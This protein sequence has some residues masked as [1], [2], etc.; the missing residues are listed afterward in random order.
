MVKKG[1]K[2]RSAWSVIGIILLFLVGAWFLA[3]LIPALIGST[4]VGTGNVARIPI[5]G[6]ILTE[7]PDSF[8][9][10]DM[11]SSTDIARFIRKADKHPTVKVIL[12]E[13]NSPGG[14]AV[15]AEEIAEAVR[16]AEKPTIA[17]IRDI[18]LSAGYWIAS[19]ADEVYASRLSLV[20]SIGVIGSYLEFSGLFDKY[21]I[22]YQRMVAGEY[23]DIG[24]P[25]KPITEREE[26]LFQTQ[27][28][29]LH[30]IFIET[31]AEQRGMAFED[32]ELLA[33]GEFFIGDIAWEHGLI[34]GTMSPARLKDHLE[35]KVGSRPSYV[36]YE[37]SKGLLGLFSNQAGNMAY[38]A[39]RGIGSSLF[40]A[41]LASSAKILI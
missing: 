17:Y 36:E 35:D 16:E 24:S 6:V 40:D 30:V 18:G 38:W 10:A 39:G 8:F 2:R 5:T 41:S 27:L 15:A 22:T 37:K 28:D 29:A 31:V 33:T 25:F 1:G 23:K 21:G 32:V 4:D 14:S 3:I 19:S 7:S 34:D 11:T 13:I 20:G 26:A 12:L 9:G